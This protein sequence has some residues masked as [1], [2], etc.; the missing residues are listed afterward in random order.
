MRHESHIV[1][2][3]EEAV[4]LCDYKAENDDFL[5]FKR[6]DTITVIQKDHLPKGL[7][8]GEIRG[9]SGLFRTKYVNMSCVS[10]KID[11]TDQLTLLNELLKHTF[12]PD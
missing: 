6:G 10:I 11:E 5:S 1:L 7:L 3:E 8:Y 2:V 4:A 12:N 9:L